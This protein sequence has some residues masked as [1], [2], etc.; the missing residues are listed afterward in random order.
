MA[1]LGQDDRLI[2]V[3]RKAVDDALKEL[4]GYAQTRVRQGRANKNRGTGNVVLAVY[5]HDT[6]RELDPQL[7]TH[8]VAAN[9]TYDGSDGRWKALQ[10]SEIYE[11]RAYLTEVYRNALAAQVRSLGY[12][13]VDRR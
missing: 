9:L 13:I 4:E 8:A 3:H 11:C 5:R 1:S 2:E 10:A 7:H 12:E 6:S